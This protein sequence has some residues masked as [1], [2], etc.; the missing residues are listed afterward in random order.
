VIAVYDVTLVAGY[1]MVGKELQQVLH[2]RRTE[3]VK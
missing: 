3:T 2:H 1:I